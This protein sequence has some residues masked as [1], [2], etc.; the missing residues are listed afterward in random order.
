MG[1]VM[2]EIEKG[3]P[4]PT[5]RG[6]DSFHTGLTER[7]RSM[8]VGDSMVF[9]AYRADKDKY[10]MYQ[11]HYRTNLRFMVR[12]QPDGSVRIWRKK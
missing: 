1:A 2:Y 11:L 7:L 10:V 6:A 9:P 3:I 12:R 4:M 5:S 8:E